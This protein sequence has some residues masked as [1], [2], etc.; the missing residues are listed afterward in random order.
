MNQ[1]AYLSSKVEAIN[2]EIIGSEDR[3]KADLTIS[4]KELE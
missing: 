1:V 2:A 3:G 4:L